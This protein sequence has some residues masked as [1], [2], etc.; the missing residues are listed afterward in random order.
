MTEQELKM[1]IDRKEHQALSYYGGSLSKERELAIEFYNGN[2]D[3]EAPE[4]TS[5][6]VSTDVRDA[7]DGMLPDILDIFLSSDDVVKFEPVG[8]EDEGGA[9]QATDAANYV[10]YKQNN[11]A[12]ILYEWFKTAMLEKN[13]VVKYW[14]ETS[15]KKTEET[16][17]ALTDAQVQSL[18]QDKNV[19]VVAHTQLEDGTHDI[20]I[21]VTKNKDKICIKPIP[22]EEFLIDIDHTSVSMKDCAFCAHRTRLTA[23]QLLEMGIDVKELGITAGDENPTAFTPEAQ[24]RRRYTEERGANVND[25]QMYGYLEAYVMADMDNDGYDELRMVRRVNGTIVSNDKF[26][27]IPFAAICPNIIPFRFHGLSIADMVLDIQKTKSVIVRQ[28]LNSLYLANN[29]RIAVQENALVDLDD[30]LVSRAGGII[31]TRVPP[32]QAMVP[33]ETRFVGQ[34]AFP[35]LEYQDT[36]KESRTGFTRYSQGMDA[37]SLNKTATGVSLI[38]T[39]SAKRQKL[40]AR[41]FAETGIKDLFKGIIF[42]L[43]KYNTKPMTIRLRNEWVDIDPRSWDTGWDMTVNVGLG[44]GDKTQQIAMLQNVVGIQNML[45]DR[46]KAYMVQD[47]N[48]YNSARRMAELSGFKQQSEFFTPPSEQNQPPQMPPPP[49]VVKMQMENDEAKMKVASAERIK[50]AEMQ[51]G[52]TI[53]NIQSQTNIAV[54]KINAEKDKEIAAAKIKADAEL[55]MF[56]ANLQKEMDLEE[57]QFTAAMEEKRRKHEESKNN[58]SEKEKEKSKPSHEIHVHYDKTRKVAKKNS[59]GSWVMESE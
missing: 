13:G 35:M 51:H 55:E 41:M 25:E 32:A 7:I 53:A 48:L 40:I 44:T 10:F 59:D 19:T 52:E 4:G 15:E 27:H 17:E 12:L 57:K 14:W 31:R 36:V 2:L 26:D 33:I 45:M 3:V 42:L 30:L 20:T 54:A 28:Q 43:N 23:S 34:Q 5:K 46:G 24:A 16:Y 37:D 47:V 1:L 38:T 11:G 58:S 29:P 6:F 21:N 50:G 49:E 56:K 9:K 8:P 22:S 18:L 39:A